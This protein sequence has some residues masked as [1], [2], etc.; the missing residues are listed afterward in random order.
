MRNK[1]EGLTKYTDC[2]M[3]TT[4]KDRIQK[5]K[6]YSYNE[7]IQDVL[8]LIDEKAKSKV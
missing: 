2:S 1:I 7:A 6:I 4:E 5:E 8:D 3:P